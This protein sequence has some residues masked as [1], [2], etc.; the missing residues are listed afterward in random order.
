MSGLTFMVPEYAFEEIRRHL[1]TLRKRS[2]IP[3]KD[4]ERL[5]ER[6]AGYFT[7]VPAD[8]VARR[9][10]EAE[11]IMAGIDPNDSAYV[12]AVLAAPCDGIWSDDPHLRR[13]PAIRCWTTPEL[14]AELT[15][16][17]MRF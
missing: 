15:A 13:Q 11:R 10:R 12:A 16:S 4:S 9:L 14:V 3:A 2:G 17:G 1:P 5:L 6:L 7:V 8:A